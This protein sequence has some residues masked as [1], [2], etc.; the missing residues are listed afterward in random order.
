[1]VILGTNIIYVQK[2]IGSWKLLYI[3]LLLVALNLVSIGSS[4]AIVAGIM[5][6]QKNAE[7]RKAWRELIFPHMPVET[8]KMYFYL[9]ESDEATLEQKQYGDIVFFPKSLGTGIGKAF[10]T[11]IVYFFHSLYNISSDSELFLRIDDD[12]VLCEQSFLHRCAHVVKSH[13]PFLYWGHM[14]YPSHSVNRVSRMD[15]EFLGLGK[16][17]VEV[18]YRN[19][20]LPLGRGVDTNYG[21]TTLGGI[22]GNL[23]LPITILNDPKVHFDDS[24]YKRE[25]PIP[26][27][28]NHCL[29]HISFHGAK[30][31]EKFAK[32]H[33]LFVNSH[34]HGN[35]STAPALA[36]RNASNIAHDNTRLV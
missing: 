36:D 6:S 16:D 7:L 11:K 29:T 35:H 30:R 27:D 20:T 32:V 21:G 4:T 26:T 15:E 34:H 22:L 12:V 14:H 33:Q 18:L 25:T 24:M 28:V 2:M 13:D 10:G 8:I 23:Q 31:Y 19:I 1:M 3:A 9:D 5:S 17:L